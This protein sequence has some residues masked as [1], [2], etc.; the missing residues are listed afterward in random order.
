MGST[1][2]ILFET[3]TWI[4]LAAGVLLALVALILTLADGTWLSASA[5]LEPSDHGR[6]ARWFTHDGGVG[7]AVLSP[8]DDAHAGPGDTVELFYRRGSNRVR[9]TA[10]WPLARLAWWLAAG[11]FALG[12]LSFLV[13]LVMM[14]AGESPG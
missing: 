4:G 10:H 13:P 9:L 11:F 12:V 3:F 6:I 14:L 8:H 5:V 2:E 1:L 7:V